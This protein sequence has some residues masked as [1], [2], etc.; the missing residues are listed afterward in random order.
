MVGWTVN[1]ELKWIWKKASW[2]DVLPGNF[3]WRDSGKARKTCQDS[4]CPDPN[5]KQAYLEYMDLHLTQNALNSGDVLQLIMKA[6][7]GIHVSLWNSSLL[8]K[9][10]KM[11]FC[12]VTQ[13]APL[14]LSLSSPAFYRNQRFIAVLRAAWYWSLARRWWLQSMPTQLIELRPIL[15]LPSHLRSSKRSNCKSSRCSG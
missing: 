6:M 15:G 11:H 9:S 3:S 1:N 8:T 7:W 4:P 10:W 13:L 5:S 12:S 14:G 2:I